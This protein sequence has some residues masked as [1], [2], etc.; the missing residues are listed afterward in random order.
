MCNHVLH[1]IELDKLVTFMEV[2]CCHAET[3]TLPNST[4]VSDILSDHYPS[5]MWCTNTCPYKM[6][7]LVYAY[8]KTTIEVQPICSV[9]SVTFI[10]R[11]QIFQIVIWTM[12]MIFRYESYSTTSR[13]YWEDIRNQTFFRTRTQNVILHCL[14]RIFFSP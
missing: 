2:C 5:N 8:S 11:H 6:Q 13:K 14:L 3:C 7:K 1:T 9:I 12:M 10:P 4:P